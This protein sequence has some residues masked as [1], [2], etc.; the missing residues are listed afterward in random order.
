MDLRKDKIKLE[1][2]IF[3]NTEFYYTDPKNI[4]GS[5][6]ILENEENTRREMEAD[7][8]ASEALIPQKDYNHFCKTCNISQS[9][10]EKFAQHIDIHPGIVVGRLQHDN[11]IKPNWFNSL[12]M[13]L[14][15]S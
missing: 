11:I 4:T 13:R 2:N 1:G 6:I 3:S 10:I 9:S 14:K 15:W 5:E 7:L 8:F 12:R